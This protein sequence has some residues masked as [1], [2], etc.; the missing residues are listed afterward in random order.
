MAV[1]MF[2]SGHISDAH[3]AVADAHACLLEA[4]RA[5]GPQATSVIEGNLQIARC[6]SVLGRPAEAAACYEAVLTALP[7]HAAAMRDLIMSKLAVLMLSTLAKGSSTEW[8]EHHVRVC[9]CCFYC[10]KIMCFM[11]LWWT[12]LFAGVCRLPP[13]AAGS[14]LIALSWPQVYSRSR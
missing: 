10:L 13:H 11:C 12:V 4:V 14:R 9:F 5:S 8:T 7:R 1:A 2:E 6:M 3:R